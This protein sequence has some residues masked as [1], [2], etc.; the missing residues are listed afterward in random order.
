MEILQPVL[1]LGLFWQES[2]VL[3]RAK[4]RYTG[5]TK[6]DELNR[7]FSEILKGTEAKLSAETGVLQQKGHSN[8]RGY[9]TQGVL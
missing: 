5:G 9:I 2:L 1:Y 4:Q 3:P 8:K 6:T 7:G